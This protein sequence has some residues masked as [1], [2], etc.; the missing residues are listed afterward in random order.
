MGRRMEAHRSMDTLC[1]T[2]S[3]GRNHTQYRP[4]DLFPPWFDPSLFQKTSWSLW[5]VPHMSLHQLALISFKMEN[6]PVFCLLMDE[7]ISIKCSY[8]SYSTK[9]QPQAACCNYSPAEWQQQNIPDWGPSPLTCESDWGFG[10]VLGGLHFPCLSSFHPVSIYAQVSH[11]SFS[12]PLWVPVS[13]TVVSLT[14]QFTMPLYH[15]SSTAIPKVCSWV[16]AP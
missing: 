11:R 13:S 1:F 12:L 7:V 3:R 10:E 5:Q 14:V 2:V 9:L 8:K 15:P 4:G 6:P 16:N